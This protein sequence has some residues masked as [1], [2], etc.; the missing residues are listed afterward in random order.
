[1]KR[2]HR[3]SVDTVRIF[4]GKKLPIWVVQGAGFEP[5]NH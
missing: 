4:D 1:M 2:S 5:A 3:V